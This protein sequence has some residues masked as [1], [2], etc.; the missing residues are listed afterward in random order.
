MHFY[1][2][3]TGWRQSVR[4]RLIGRGPMKGMA[5]LSA[6]RQRGSNSGLSAVTKGTLLRA[7]LV[8][9][10]PPPPRQPGGETWSQRHNSPIP[11]CGAWPADCSTSPT[12]PS[13]SSSC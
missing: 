3:C 10:I 6:A 11:P 12:S 5:V 4:V 7:V 8:Y 9:P 13:A 2:W 1:L